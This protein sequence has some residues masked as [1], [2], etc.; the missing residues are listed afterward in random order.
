[1]KV[2]VLIISIFSLTLLSC[3]QTPGEP[4]GD[5]DNAMD[6]YFPIDDL[7]KPKVYHYKPGNPNERDMYWV[8]YV[9]DTLGEEFLITDSY[10][11]DSKGV[12]LHIE[13]LKEKITHQTAY[14][15]DYTMIY[16][17]YHDTEIP[18]RSHIKSD[19]VFQ[20]QLEKNESFIWSYTMA[21]ANT[22]NVK[23]QMQRTR[24]YTGNAL[25]FSFDKKKVKALVF[26]DK[27]LIHRTK[28]E[29]T[30]ET[31]VYDQYSYYAKGIGLIYYK[32]II[33]EKTFEY[34]LKSIY[35]VNNPNVPDLIKEKYN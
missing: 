33:G 34:E 14:I 6:Y 15:E 3:E 35:D 11:V 5:V 4:K 13:W 9:E 24:K 19:V 28:F 25:D 7:K 21:V 10:S 27:Y 23:E 16:Y 20:G 2:L 30:I 29:K 12:I 8:L 22:E 31:A 32:R 1:M 26:K 17:G 18:I